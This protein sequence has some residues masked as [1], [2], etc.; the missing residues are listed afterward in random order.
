MAK[1]LSSISSRKERGME[2]GGKGKRKRERWEN[3]RQ[4]IEGFTI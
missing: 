1:V 4:R 2:G 3:E